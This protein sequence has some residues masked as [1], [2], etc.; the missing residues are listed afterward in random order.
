[1][2]SDHFLDSQPLSNAQADRMVDMG[3]LPQM[4]A[5]YELLS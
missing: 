2:C 1:M 5:M 3:F 4:E